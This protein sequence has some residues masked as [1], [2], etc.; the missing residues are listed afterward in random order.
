MSS[1]FP[2]RMI[3]C[4]IGRDFIR[5]SLVYPQD[6]QITNNLKT[7]LKLILQRKKKTDS[8]QT[9]HSA[10]TPRPRLRQRRQ[11]RNVVLLRLHS[12]DLF[13]IVKLSLGPKLVIP[14]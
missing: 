14:V 12:V 3:F 8:L 4:I 6:I 10:K 7:F 5:L 9:F 1:N 11:W 2:V 13:S